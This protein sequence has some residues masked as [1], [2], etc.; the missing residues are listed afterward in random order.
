MTKR[1]FK[2]F[3]ITSLIPVI[4]LVALSAKGFIT[5]PKSAT[6]SENQTVV[7]IELNEWS[8]NPENFNVSG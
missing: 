4:L 5:E 1:R 3:F 2:R 8:I 6:V 7:E